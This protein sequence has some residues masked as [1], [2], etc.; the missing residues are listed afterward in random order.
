MLCFLLNRTG[1]W[2]PLQMCSRISTSI[3]Q[4]PFVPQMW[5]VVGTRRVLKQFGVGTA[6]HPNT[7]VCLSV[8][9]MQRGV[10]HVARHPQEE[11]EEET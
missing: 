3:R 1:C 2:G 8:I 5:G 11:Q 9:L 4:K 6:A 7:A 10:V